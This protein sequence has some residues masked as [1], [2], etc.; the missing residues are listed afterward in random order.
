M[1]KGK[2]TF[3]VILKDTSKRHWSGVIFAYLISGSV[4]DI[5][6]EQKVLATAKRVT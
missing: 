2:F 3:C 5:T 1:E 6:Y 4:A